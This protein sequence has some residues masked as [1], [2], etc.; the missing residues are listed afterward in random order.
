MESGFF[1]H[2]KD[3]VFM[4]IAGYAAIVSTVTV[5][6]AVLRDRRRI[7]VRYNFPFFISAGGS[8]QFISVEVVNA[9]HRPVS[10]T[11]LGFSIPDGHTLQSVPPYDLVQ[12]QMNTN[13]PAE[14]ADGG[15]AQMV[16][17]LEG[18]YNSLRRQGYGGEIRL[19]PQATDSLGSVYSGKSVSLKV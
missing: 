10:I 16:L 19:T 3:I 15:R 14:L 9:G 7:R 18:V 17:D 2:T 8:Q 5:L 11:Q 13:L 12:S 1:V 6:R 4:A